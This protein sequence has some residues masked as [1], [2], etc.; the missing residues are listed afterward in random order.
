LQ[1]RDGWILEALA[2]CRF[3]TTRH[4]AALF[5]EDSL[6]AT[7][8]RLRKMLNVGL[9]HAWVRRLDSENIYYLT[10]RGANYVGKSASK[11]QREVE[12]ID[13]I[14]L[15]NSIRVAFARGLERVDAFI[16]QWR[17]D[18]E[19]RRPFRQLVPDAAVTIQWAD[20]TVGTFE[21]EADNST[22]SARAFL[23]KML[24]YSTRI[25]AN[26]AILVVA[27]DPKWAERYLAAMR[28]Q[29]FVLPAWFTSLRALKT[30]FC[31]PIWRG[32]GGQNL[33]LRDIVSRPCRKEGLHAASGSYDTELH[34]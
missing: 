25:T 29:P 32:T 26:S 23:Q 17:S 12:Q 16:L 21:L 24:R 33:S 19:L 2:S 28:Q 6:S 9:I 34:V 13:H 22:R 15:I 7:N 14:L 1:P 31:D 4:L 10:Q 5:F 8:K 30:S 3:L 20:K 27:S 18:W 11:P